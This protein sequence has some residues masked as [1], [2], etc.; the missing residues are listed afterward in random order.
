MAKIKYVQRQ[1]RSATVVII[2]AA[3]EIIREYEEDNMTL[4]VR[5]LYYQ[6]IARDILS[7]DWIDP[8]TGSK[9]NPKSYGKLSS[10]I[11][12]AR[13]AGLIDWEAITDKTRNLQTRPYWSNPGNII[14]SAVRAFKVD[15]WKNQRH[16][17]EVWIEK[18][19]LV[20]IIEPICE[21]LDV[22]Y[23][24]C[25]GFV[26]QSEMWSASRR[27]IRYGEEGIQCIIIHLGDHDPSGI[28]MSRD[29][30]DRQ[31]IFLAN[32]VTVHRI[33]LNYNQIE[34][35]NPPPNP[36]KITDTRAKSYMD[37][38]G[39]SSWELDALE[40]RVVRDLVRR[41]ILLYR[42]EDVYEETINEENGYLETLYR[43]E[44]NWRNL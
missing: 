30:E 15:R 21:E 13:L 35:Y 11:S 2:D 23:F 34:E 19:A 24:A 36:A 39:I 43:I 31:N 28:D 20:G 9:N 16:R 12:T 29:I 33:A 26:S 25:K 18:E 22:P 5:Q 42:D 7:E 37:R 40:P 10:I 41:S 38:F 3:N 8:N 14:A 27:F 1:F 17:V 32:N 4:T 44:A 6:F